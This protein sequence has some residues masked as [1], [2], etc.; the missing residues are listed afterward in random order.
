V[1]SR[2]HFLCCLVAFYVIHIEQDT[3]SAKLRADDKNEQMAQDELFKENTVQYSGCRYF[4][5]YTA[6]IGSNTS[7]NS[8]FFARFAS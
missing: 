3:G 4:S 2:V 7:S 8:P 6:P 5:G 1:V